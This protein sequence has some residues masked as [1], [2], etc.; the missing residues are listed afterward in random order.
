MVSGKLK[1]KACY[2]KLCLTFYDYFL[3]L[4]N[5]YLE[6]KTLLWIEYIK[7]MYLTQK[8]LCVP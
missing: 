7:Q 8:H 1:P 4:A 3:K 5:D 6:R 2:D